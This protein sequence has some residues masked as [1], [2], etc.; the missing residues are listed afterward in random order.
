VR[1][2]KRKRLYEPTSAGMKALKDLRRVRE[3]LWEAIES[4]GEV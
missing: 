1:G 2:G 4:R 3:R